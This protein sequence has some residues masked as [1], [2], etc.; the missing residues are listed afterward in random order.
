VPAG[1]SGGTARSPRDRSGSGRPDIVIINLAGTQT[2]NFLKQYSEFGLAFPVAGFGFDTALAWGAG[3]GNFGGIW[4]VVWHHLI[5]TP[6][7]KAFVAGFQRKWNRMPE[8]QA[9]GDYCSMKV[10]A[11]TIAETKSTDPVKIVEHLE[12]GAKFDLL[13]TR[14]GYFRASDHQ[15]MMEM[16]A[17]T[18]LPAAQVKNQYD[19]F[20]SSPPVP[21]PGEILEPPPATAEENQCRFPT[22]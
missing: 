16:Y 7:S 2:T 1:S 9:W 17:I 21:G 11:Q 10:V 22:T 15:M 6:G 13:K 19:L 4:P 12:K 20:T 8:N 5:D 18:A 3:K 14:E